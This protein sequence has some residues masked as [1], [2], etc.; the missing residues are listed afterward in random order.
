MSIGNIAA[1]RSRNAELR[2]NGNGRVKADFY[3]FHAS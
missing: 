1:M 3:D 2:E